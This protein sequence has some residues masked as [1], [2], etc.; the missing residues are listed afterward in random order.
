M[1]RYDGPQDYV[2]YDLRDIGLIK[3]VCSE[4]GEPSVG[5]TTC[6]AYMIPVIDKT[7]LSGDV[8]TKYEEMEHKGTLRHLK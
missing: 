8:L 4:C 1:S 2:I 7:V 5:H 3:Y 6:S